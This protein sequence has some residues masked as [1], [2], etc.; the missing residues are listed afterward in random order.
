MSKQRV[1]PLAAPYSQAVAEAFSIVMPP[2]MPPLNIF[3]TVGNN[4]RVLSRMVRGGLL[5]RGS[6]TLA[7]RE[8]VVLRACARCRAEYE[9]G[10]HAALFAD[11]AGFT[12]E[13]LWDTTEPVVETA[14]WSDRQISLIR[15]VDELHETAAVS[16]ELWRELKRYFSDVQLI[17]LV[18]LAGLY[19][20]VSFLVN[21]LQIE[22]ESFAPRFRERGGAHS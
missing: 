16:D 19:H 10:V 13:Q 20:A 5:D 14:L 12:P 11:R 4:E 17:E 3:R 22:K 9:W 8:L 6:I 2:G 18:M 1:Q 15:L 7:E 21:G